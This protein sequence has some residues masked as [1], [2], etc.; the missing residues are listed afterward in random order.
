MRQPPKH[1][2]AKAAITVWRLTGII[3]FIILM[4]TVGA[5]TYVAYRFEWPWFISA[6]AISLTLFEAS[7]HILI[8]PNIRYKRFRYEILDEEIYIQRGLLIVTRTLVPMTRIQH[9]DTKQGPILKKYN[10]MTVTISTAATTHEIPALPSEEADRL[11]N[12]IAVRAR[13]IEDD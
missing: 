2:L 13:V 9:V 10:L 5:L 8:I 6:I 11:R 12:D 4:M 7:V 3:T 1:Q